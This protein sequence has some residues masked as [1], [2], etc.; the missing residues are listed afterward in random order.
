MMVL[1]VFGKIQSSP[2]LP[3][4][5]NYA[6]NDPQTFNFM[7]FHPCQTQLSTLKLTAIL[8]LVLDSEFLYFDPQL[9]NKLLIF[10][11]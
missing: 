1:K 5:F 10:S 7:Q 4:T 9:T 11:I 2:I 6:C 3:I 8:I